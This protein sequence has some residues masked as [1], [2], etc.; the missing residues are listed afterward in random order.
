MSFFFD[1]VFMIT[2][3]RIFPRY[4]TPSGHPIRTGCSIQGKPATLL[5]PAAGNP[6]LAGLPDAVDLNQT[7]RLFLDDFEDLVTKR[8]HQF[9][10]KVRP[11]A[12]DESGA[13][14]PL[15]SFGAAGMGSAN[16]VSF[17]LLSMVTVYDPTTFG[18]NVFARYREREMSHERDEVMLILDGGLEDREAVVGVVK[19]HAFD[20]ADEGF[21][22]TIHAGIITHVLE[23]P[24][25]IFW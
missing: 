7:P 12:F 21:W 1:L 9:R 18:F 10:R 25:R 19:C 5:M 20:A 11:D 4:Q 22:A 24:M 14:L 6:L 23:D 17:E 2:F 15:H 3:Q 16:R 8:L 13:Q